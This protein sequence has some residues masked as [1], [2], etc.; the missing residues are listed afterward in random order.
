M[1][2]QH[3][4]ENGMLKDG[5]IKEWANSASKNIESNNFWNTSRILRNM[6]TEHFFDLREDFIIEEGN[7]ILRTE[8]R[9][10]VIES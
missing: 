8:G 9:V 7:I 10:G 6:K 3:Y 5:T 1:I 4:K 2:F